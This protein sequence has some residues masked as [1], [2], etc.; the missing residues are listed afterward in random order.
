MLGDVRQVL[1]ERHR[2]KI[3]SRQKIHDQ[4]ATPCDGVLIKPVEK[5]LVME[6][7]RNIHRQK[8]KKK[9][10]HEKWTR[11]REVSKAIESLETS[12]K[13]DDFSPSSHQCG[14]AVL[15]S[16]SRCKTLNG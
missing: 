13:V 7:I 3:A 10:E 12:S 9:L 15:S 8:K 6:I 14:H 11:P 1:D 4:I 16:T 5:V 2:S